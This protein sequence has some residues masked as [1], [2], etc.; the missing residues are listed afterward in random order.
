MW[1]PPKLKKQYV[2]NYEPGKNGKRQLRLE[3]RNAKGQTIGEVYPFGN[4]QAAKKAGWIYNKK[5]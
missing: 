5:G 4:A 2:G 1:S 3:H